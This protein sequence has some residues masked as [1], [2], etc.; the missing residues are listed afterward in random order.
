MCF[1]SQQLQVN[2]S[3]DW[4]HLFLVEISAAWRWL[5]FSEVGFVHQAWQ[6]VSVFQAEVVVRTKHVG[7]DHSRVASSIL[8]IIASA[9]H[10]ETHRPLPF[11]NLSEMKNDFVLVKDDDHSLGVG[12]SIVWCVRWSQMDL[13]CNEKVSHFQKQ[14]SE[15]EPRGGFTLD[16]S[17]G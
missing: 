4:C 9:K 5:T 17:M 11:W 16:S 13:W 8:L 3:A 14:V 7:R 15:L 6:H 12:I 10:Q 2:V 1:Y